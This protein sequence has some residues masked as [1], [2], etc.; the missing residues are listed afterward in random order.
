MYA[1]C[2]RT[3]P[4]E[5]KSTTNRK[6]TTSCI[7]NLQQIHVLEFGFHKLCQNNAVKPP[8]CNVCDVARSSKDHTDAD[9][10]YD[11]SFHTMNRCI[12]KV[13][14][15]VYKVITQFHKIYIEI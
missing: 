2:C 11:N 12:S 14:I 15:K 9:P 10:H 5:K 6:P 7:T 3:S 13:K 4:Q 8:L 1:I